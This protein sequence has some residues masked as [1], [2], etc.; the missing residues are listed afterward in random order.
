[1]PAVKSRGAIKSTLAAIAAH[2]TRVTCFMVFAERTA[3]PNEIAREL[4]QDVT[5]VS[6]HVKKLLELQAIEKVSEQPVRGAIEHFY[7][8]IERPIVSGED[9]AGLSREERAVISQEILQ[10]HVADLCQALESGTFDDRIDRSVIRVPVLLDEEG[11]RELRDLHDETYERTLEIQA[12]S[13]E[14]MASDSEVEQIQ[15]MSTT[16]FYQRAKRPNRR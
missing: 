2:P 8:A 10:R 14:R 1:M 7:R 12:K 13:A 15:T 11:F 9:W 16:M 6:Y 3:S 5:H 4:G